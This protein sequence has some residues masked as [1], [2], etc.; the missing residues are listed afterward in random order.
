[1]GRYST[2]TTKVQ[3]KLA[4]NRLKLVQNKKQNLA[5]QHKHEIAAL[6]QQGKDES[7]RIR[8]ENVIREDLIIEAYELIE[9]FCELV[10]ARL[11]LLDTQSDVPPELREAICTIIY[12]APRCSD[13]PE[14]G[15][16]REQF[17]GKYGK[18]FLF[19]A[20]SNKNDIV[21]ARVVHKLNYATPDQA[22]VIQY[23]TEI[24]KSHGLPFN[25]DGL[26]SS[27][28]LKYPKESSTGGAPGVGPGPGPQ[29]F[30]GP[31][32]QPGGGFPGPGVPVF[33][34]PGGYQQ[35]PYPGQPGFP[36][37]ATGFPPGG[38]GF[39]FPVNRPISPNFNNNSSPTQ[40]SNTN[41]PPPFG[42]N[43]APPSISSSLPSVP[44]GKPA[45]KDDDD[46]NG[47]GGD[48]NVPDFDELTARFE[49]LKKRG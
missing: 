4:I 28:I 30:P 19:V 43:D 31:G 25:P 37:G 13:I 1:M 11:P 14:L 16:L 38:P 23:L 2:P 34:V 12:C 44:N 29:G 48:G 17:G 46:G 42:V 6:I 27:D 40:P 24:A 21:N 10:Q 5:K 7:A 15:N 9:L 22:L 36:P 26:I 3:L 32:S 33:P 8:V 39:G 41:I 45:G 49:A 20:N 35:Y 47:D 18:E